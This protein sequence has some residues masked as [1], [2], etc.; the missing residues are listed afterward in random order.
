MCDAHNLPFKNKV[1]DVVFESGVL[2]YC[3]DKNRVLGEMQRVGRKVL[4]SEPLRTF[5]PH[6][7][8][9]KHWLQLKEL[10][11]IGRIRGFIGIPFLSGT[12]IVEVDI[13]GKV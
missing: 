6:R 12:C 2:A 8:R 1:F 10:L 5:F 9:R 7:R 11:K 13:N 4:V 3:K